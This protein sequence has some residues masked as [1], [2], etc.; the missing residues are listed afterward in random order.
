MA[1]RS[2]AYRLVGI[3]LVALALLIGLY[4]AVAYIGLQSGRSLREERLQEEREAE[5]ENQV[6]RAQSDI[7]SGNYSLAV[8]RLEWVLEQEPTYPL[9]RGLLEV[10]EAGEG[11]REHPEIE[12]TA[13]ATAEPQNGPSETVS[14]EDAAAAA[15][16]AQVEPLLEAQAWEEAITALTSLQHDYPN[17]R[18]Q[19][20]DE[21]LHQATIEHG[22][23]L[24]YGDQI[25]LG[26]YY[27][28]Q[29]ERL[30]SLPQEVRDQRQWAELYLGGI[31]YFG[32]NWDVTLFY[33]RDLCLAAPFFH[34]A[35]VKLTE[36]LLAYG[37]Q[38]AVQQEWCPA[39]A[40]YEEAYRQ[41]DSNSVT[42]KL[43]QA[44]Q[45]CAEATPTPQAPISGTVP[46]TDTPTI[47]NTSPLLPGPN[48]QRP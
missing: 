12:Q 10:A 16:F 37:D 33:F 27:L 44:R 14:A 23:E 31:G 39:Q 19:E 13:T 46:I 7:E 9:A 36:A 43:R 24:L 41:D 8:R 30:G 29:A 1:G 35:C 17:Y 32:V 3:V 45:G 2:R 34:D 48:L 22:V 20:T 5:L 4:T 25:E 6:E 28:E 18:R 26:L 38:Y 15:A 40:L 47:T 11:G 21:M 42:Q